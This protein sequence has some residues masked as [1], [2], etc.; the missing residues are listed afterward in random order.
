VDSA[1]VIVVIVA[2]FFYTNIA[3]PP[4]PSY[5]CK[6]L[7]RPTEDHFPCLTPDC[8]REQKPC[9]TRR[10]RRGGGDR[11][12]GSVEPSLLIAVLNISCVIV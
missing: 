5:A 7:E 12:L 10:K 8:G 1:A 4:R 9:R 2:A 11:W 6:S 3:G